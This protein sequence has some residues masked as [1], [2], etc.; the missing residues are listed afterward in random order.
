MLDYQKMYSIC[1]HLGCQV[2]STAYAS[3]FFKDYHERNTT[4]VHSFP[5]FCVYSIPL[6]EY[7]VATCV[8]LLPIIT[9]WQAAV[10]H[11]R[12]QVYA[13]APQHDAL[14]R[15]CPVSKP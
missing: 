8:A 1:R 9:L 5:E 7:V 4:L 6:E 10:L 3:P 15:S 14:V 2:C 12:P 13:D 11:C